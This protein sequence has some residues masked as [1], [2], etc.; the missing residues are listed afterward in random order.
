MQ[1]LPLATGVC[2]KVRGSVHVELRGQRDD[3]GVPRAHRVGTREAGIS[4]ASLGTYTAHAARC[5]RRLDLRK[6]QVDEAGTIVSTKAV[7]RYHYRHACTTQRE[8][9]SVK[10]GG[11]RRESRVGKAAFDS[12]IEPDTGAAT[13]RAAAPVGHH[14]RPAQKVHQALPA[15]LALSGIKEDRRRYNSL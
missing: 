9:G 1:H 11:G 13:L 12:Q 7:Q 4:I 5:T 14:E 3:C 2:S 15:A 8:G 10:S 6:P